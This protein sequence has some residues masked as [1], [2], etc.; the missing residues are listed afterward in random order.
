VDWNK[1][2]EWEQVTVKVTA[3]YDCSLFMGSF[4]CGTD[5]VADI[6]SSSTLNYQEGPTRS[7]QGK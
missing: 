7:Q 3:Q 6:S 2:K 4:L 5:E 1:A